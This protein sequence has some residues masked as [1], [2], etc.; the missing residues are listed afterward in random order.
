MLLPYAQVNGPDKV[1][2]E[3]TIEFIDL[4]KS[5]VT[6]RPTSVYPSGP[7]DAVVPTKSELKLIGLVANAASSIRGSNDSI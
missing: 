3:I 2:A 1:F 4:F 5:P 6:V 7:T